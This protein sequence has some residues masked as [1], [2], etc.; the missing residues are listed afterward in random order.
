MNTR[1]QLRVLF[2]I[3]LVALIAA[4]C[5]KFVSAQQVTYYTFDDAPG[6]YSN[7][8]ADPAVTPSAPANN[9]LC[10]NNG[11]GSGGAVPSFLIADQGSGIGEICGSG[12]TRCPY[13]DMAYHTAIQ[14]TTGSMSQGSSVWFSI[15]QKVTNGFTSYFAFRITR[16]EGAT[17]DGL[18]FLVQNSTNPSPSITHGSGPN[19]LGQLGGG[20][21]YDGIDN[22]LAV[23]F[24]TFYNSEFGDTAYTSAGYSFDSNHIA[25]QSCGSGVNNSTHGSGGCQVGSGFNDSLPFQ[26]ADGR[27]HEVVIEFTGPAAGS[28]P[29]YFVYL[30][31]TFETGTHTPT[32]APVLSVHYDLISLNLL[33]PNGDSAYVGFTSSTGGSVEDANLLA[34][35]F[36][37][38]TPVITQPQP[39]ADGAPTTFPFGAH[40]YAVTYP[41]GTN[42]GG[43]TD[44][45][46]IASTIDP[47]PDFANLVA[48][49]PFAG[50]QCQIYEGTGG[51][52]II[53]SVYCIQHPA[54]PTDPQVKVPCPSTS[55]PIIG[56]KTAYESDGSA[57]ATPPAPGFLHGDPFY[58]P[59]TSIQGNGTTATATCTGQCSV[60]DGNS[61]SIRGNAVAGLNAENVTP[62]GSTLDTFTYPITSGVTTS[63][64]GGFVTSTNI[65]NIC[66][67]PPFNAS[68][69]PC[70]Q[71][72]KIDGTTSGKTKNFSDLAALFQT[73][74]APTITS[75]NSTTFTAGVFGNF[76]VSTTGYPAPAITLSGDTLPNGVTFVDNHVGTG[77]LSGTPASG[78]ANTYHLTFTVASPVLP[79]AVQPFTLTVLPAALTS[80]TVAPASASINVGQT[81]QFTATG[82]YGDGSTQN[83]SSSV[84]WHSSNGAAA[85]I[86]TT[87]LASGL[88]SGSSNITATSGAITSN[89]AV[90]TVNAVVA[91]A[92]ITVTPS[93]LAFGDVY[94]GSKKDINV[95]VKNVSSASVTI[96]KIYFNYGH[97]GSSTNY[98]YTTQCGGPIKAGKTCTIQVELKAQDV[99]P[100]SSQLGIT[101]SAPGSPIL[102][103]LTGN[104]INPKASVS[105][106]SINFGTIKVNTTLSKTVVI[107]S[108][109]DTPLLISNVALS[110]STDFTKSGSCAASLS[111]NQSCTITVTF[112]PS[113]KQ[114]RTGTLKFTD[115]ATSSPQSV[116]LSGKGN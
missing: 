64:A 48:G 69:P 63:G 26:M 99:G 2:L 19:V 115:N 10:L 9:L 96:T 36:T 7:S 105:P 84:T 37:P 75:G 51:K 29:N 6:N 78:T 81:Q 53:Y 3:V 74:S 76:A 85:S 94:L 30:D 11:T 106:S 86:S 95:T 4:A 52:C 93:S 20:I 46:T 18:A 34:W 41:T 60:T 56:V 38:H 42:G 35:T 103:G 47:L 17:A 23:E 72:A 87:G 8:C 67:V 5:P 44:M 16:T 57:S 89:T 1:S 66:D 90:L 65:Q 39:I 55:S 58:S 62:T 100:G 68:N 24:D 22:S 50:S 15:P 59:I 79:N 97:G 21:G 43:G 12:D 109:G 92:A 13:N 116:S 61:V 28:T 33:G 83:L 80:I 113:A 112:Q 71:T 110:G 98:G 54:Q 101:Y 73:S 114:S 91:P 32:S 108:T 77:T 88:A 40:T 102:I 27:I 70:Y 45:I 111:K 82:N 104:V 14:M 107:T 49:T 25:V 31:P